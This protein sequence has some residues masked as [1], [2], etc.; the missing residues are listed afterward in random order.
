MARAVRLAIE[1]SGLTQRQIADKFDVT[2]QAVSGWQ[3]TGKID[4]RK[5]PQLARL[6]KLPL[7]HFDMGEDSPTPT[8]APSHPATVAGLMAQLG[9]QLNEVPLSLRPAV[10]KLLESLVTTPDDP[11]LRSSLEALLESG[12]PR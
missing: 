6:A 9:Q 5:L 2:E 11:T 3:R 8:T 12:K 10:A 7:S 4:K 1:A